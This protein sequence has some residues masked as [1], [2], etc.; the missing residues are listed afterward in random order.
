MTVGFVRPRETLKVQV[1]KLLWECNLFGGAFLLPNAP[2][3]VLAPVSVDGFRSFVLAL[4]EKD[5]EVTNANIGC[6]FVFC[7]E[8]GLWTV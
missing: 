3:A 7:D 4:E 1:W 5:V 2:Y 8:F 6:L